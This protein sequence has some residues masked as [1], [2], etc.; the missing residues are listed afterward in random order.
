MFRLCLALTIILSVN[1]LQAAEYFFEKGEER[2]SVGEVSDSAS[3]EEIH[4]LVKDVILEDAKHELS[5]ELDTPKSKTFKLTQTQKDCIGAGA[6]ILASYTVAKYG[7]AD[8][9]DKQKHVIAGAFISASTYLAVKNVLPEE[10]SELTKEV[11][12]TTA[13]VVA[14]T[15][16]AVGKEVYD[17][18]GHGTKDKNDAIAT[19][20]GGGITVFTINIPF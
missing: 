8:Q 9:K 4:A 7:Y 16:V 14:T 5:K 2:V 1:G 17:G 12:A 15:T 13:A 18:E 19:M 10:L 6:G 3:D 20:V 11:I